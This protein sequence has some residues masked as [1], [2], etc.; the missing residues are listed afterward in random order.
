MLISLTEYAAQHGKA[1]SSA[2]QM[3]LRGGFKTAQKIGRNWVIDSDEPWPDHRI[4][5]G[6]YIKSEGKQMCRRMTRTID[7][8]DLY[9][10]IQF[11]DFSSWENPEIEDMCLSIYR[12]RIDT[13]MQNAGYYWFPEESKIAVD[14]H[15]EEEESAPITMAQKERARSIFQQAAD[16]AW[17]K[18]IAMDEPGVRAAYDAL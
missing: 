9:S 12:N 6:K 16:D 8:T 1:N 3:A 17:N 15:T 11:P 2:R 7:E 14:C 10:D 5:S 18:I 4:K 13:A